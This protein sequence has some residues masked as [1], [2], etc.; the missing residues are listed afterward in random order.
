[1]PEHAPTLTITDADH[2]HILTRDCPLDNREIA[3]IA[4]NEAAR[5][6]SSVY[7]TY[8]NPLKS[9]EYITTIF[10]PILRPLHAQSKKAT[11]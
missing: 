9:D 4:R 1:M 11:T 7:A 10:N 8:P 6:K 5:L 2:N 3:V